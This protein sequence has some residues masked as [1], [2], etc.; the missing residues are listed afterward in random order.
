V[1]A[2]SSSEASGEYS[3]VKT[4]S[5]RKRKLD[6]R[7][8]QEDNKTSTLKISNKKGRKKEEIKSPKIEF[9]TASQDETD[10][11]TKSETSNTD[12]A[13]TIPSTAFQP[14]IYDNYDNSQPHASLKIKLQ[15]T[16]GKG[17]T[18]TP[19]PISIAEEVPSS[20][21]PVL[22]DWLNIGNATLNFH[23]DLV[24][25]A[26]SNSSKINN[27]NIKQNKCVTGY[28]I[29]VV[30]DPVLANGGFYDSTFDDS[31]FTQDIL[32]IFDF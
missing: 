17:V 10:E 7:A 14:D 27:M 1:H 22:D 13:L 5:K 8:N 28:A 26:D 19:S 23:T 32:E 6:K 30:V 18:G 21:A 11:E 20:Q 9:D 24:Q 29:P 4:T 25:D 16:N 15:K 3:F 2:F 12:I 31:V